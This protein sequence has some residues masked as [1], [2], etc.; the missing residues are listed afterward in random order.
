MNEREWDEAPELEKISFG[1]E[2]VTPDGEQGK[3]CELDGDS[4]YKYLVVSNTKHLGW[5][6]REDLTLVK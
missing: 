4:D 5:Y 2:V 6:A 1:D 3:V